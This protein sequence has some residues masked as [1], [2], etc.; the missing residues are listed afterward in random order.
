MEL[1]R[2]HDLQEK[3][4]NKVQQL[5]ENIKAFLCGMFWMNLVA[6]WR[7]EPVLEQEDRGM[8]ASRINH[9]SKH[10]KN[11]KWMGSILW[12]CIV[13]DLVSLGNLVS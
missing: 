1:I 10:V 12:R 7:A 6:I 13:M 8:C 9:E 4:Y 11:K 5:L 3:T 2:E